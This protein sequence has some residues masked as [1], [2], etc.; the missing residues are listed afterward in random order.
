MTTKKSTHR[1]ASPPVIGRA[2]INPAVSSAEVRIVGAPPVREVTEEN[3]SEIEA[4]RF[5][6]GAAVLPLY[7]I[8]EV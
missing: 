5:R 3:R 1:P 4:L 6:H 7:I 8:E 2:R